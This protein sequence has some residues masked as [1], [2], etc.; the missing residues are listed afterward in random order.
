MA[1][2]FVSDSDSEASPPESETQ[3]LRPA[4]KELGVLPSPSERSEILRISEIN[5]RSLVGGSSYYVGG[6]SSSLAPFRFPTAR[7]RSRPKGRA[8]KSFTLWGV[9]SSLLEVCSFASLIHIPLASSRSD[10]KVGPT[11][12]RL[13]GEFLS[14]SESCS[15]SVSPSASKIASNFTILRFAS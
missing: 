1:R 3:S 10:L 9:S 5:G 11:R 7:V 6:A 15:V 4:R 12:L 13:V 14:R 2:S 8:P